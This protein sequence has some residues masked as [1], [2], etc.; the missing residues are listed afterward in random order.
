MQ[1]LRS[2][3]NTLLDNGVTFYDDA[4]PSLWRQ[5]VPGKLLKVYRDV[6]TTFATSFD[7]NLTG[8]SDN[9]IQDIIQNGGTFDVSTGVM[10]IMI[11]HPRIADMHYHYQ[12]NIAD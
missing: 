8:V 5:Q 7:F 1:R 11:D 6:D 4:Y 9:T 12:N 3:Q 10:N 2:I